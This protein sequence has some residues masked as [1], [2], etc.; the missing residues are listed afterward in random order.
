MEK[1]VTGTSAPTGELKSPA[2]E[3]KTYIAGWYKTLRN[4]ALVIL[5]SIL[6]YVG[7][8]IMLSS[9]ASDKAKYKQMLGD[10]VV[11]VCLLFLMHYIMSFLYI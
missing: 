9:V 3:L 8:R 11:A 6:V 4:L 5:L 2:N 10:W 1:V 7:I